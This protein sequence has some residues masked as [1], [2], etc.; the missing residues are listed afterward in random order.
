MQI[1]D[2]VKYIGKDN[3]LNKNRGIILNIDML[4][5]GDNGITIFTV[6]WKDNEGLF[7]RIEYDWNLQLDN[8]EKKLKRILK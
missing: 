7:V 2:T 3:P 6:K 1:G 4:D 8:R 5:S